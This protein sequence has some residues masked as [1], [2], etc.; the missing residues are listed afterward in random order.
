MNDPRIRWI[1]ALVMFGCAVC[2]T[3]TAQA[4]DASPMP[5]NGDVR[6][7]SPDRPLGP[8]NNAGFEHHNQRTP[9]R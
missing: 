7:N 1:I 5:G 4:H 2:I 9:Y 6:P 3:A 8:S